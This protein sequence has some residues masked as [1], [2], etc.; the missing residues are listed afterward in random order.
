MVQMKDS[1]H[2]DTEILRHWITLEENQP[3]APDTRG[4]TVANWVKKFSAFPAAV[5]PLSG[6]PLELARQLVVNATHRITMRF[7]PGVE[8][9]TWRVVFEGVNYTIGNVQ[10]PDNRDRKLVL[11]C[12]TEESK[13]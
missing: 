4:Q 9:V 2:F 11:T 3:E 7:L 12:F 13:S 8:A 5:E 10:N 1:A 6:R